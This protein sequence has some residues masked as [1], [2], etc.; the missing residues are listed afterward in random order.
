MLR[1]D[2]SR[3]C[4]LMLALT[5]LLWLPGAAQA[6]DW[7]PKTVRIVVPFAPGST[8]DLVGRVLADSLQARHPGSSFVVE[9]KPGA[10]GDIGISFA[11]KA[12][13]DGYTLLHAPSAITLPSSV[14][15]S[16]RMRPWRAGE[17]GRRRELAGVPLSPAHAASIAAAPQSP[18]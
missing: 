8:P 13:P 16:S 9:N 18:A 14:R 3:A 17:R 6:Q 11:A 2:M 7:P 1:N 4:R 10:G 12:N 15:S 5:A